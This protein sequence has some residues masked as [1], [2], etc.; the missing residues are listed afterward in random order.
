MY[1]EQTIIL[2]LNFSGVNYAFFQRARNLETL[3]KS[4][5]YFAI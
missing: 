3:Y 5:V 4:F 1:R 2:F